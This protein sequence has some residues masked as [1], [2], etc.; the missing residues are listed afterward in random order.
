MTDKQLTK[1]EKEK[2]EAMWNIQ[3]YRASSP[4]FL[5]T[6]VF[7][8]FFNTSIEPHDS[9]TDFGCGS[10]FSALAFLENEL[11]VHLI[12]I[13]SNALADKIVALTLLYPNQIKFTQSCLWEL[14]LEI[15]CSDWS[16]CV[17]VLEHLPTE[18]IDPVLREIAKRTKKGGILQVFLQDE[19]F[20]NLIGETLHLTIKPLP[21]WIQKINAHFSILG[22]AP[23]IPN[24]RYTI[25]VAPKKE[26]EPNNSKQTEKHS[27]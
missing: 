21:W 4:G 26:D 22:V 23:I 25:F 3:S 14:P 20:G 9:I 7:F 12:D 18:K 11:K 2:Y 19:P 27:K 8:D 5:L 10:G 15:P 24:V 16:Y 1:Q 17:D 6:S 13:A